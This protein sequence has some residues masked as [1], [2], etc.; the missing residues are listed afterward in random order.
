MI[1][2]RQGRARGTIAPSPRLAD[3]YITPAAVQTARHRHADAARMLDVLIS[4]APGHARACRQSF[5]AESSTGRMR[6]LIRRS[7]P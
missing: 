7:G 5:D 6:L 1:W 2:S 4:F 3:A